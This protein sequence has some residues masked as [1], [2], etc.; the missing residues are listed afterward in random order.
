MLIDDRPTQAHRVSSARGEAAG[1]CAASCVAASASE[2]LEI[3]ASV[4]D[5]SVMAESSALRVVRKPESASS[6]SMEIPIE[7][8]VLT[9]F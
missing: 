4:E 5:S 7:Q 8:S 3:S 2:N 9:P 6:D 1:R